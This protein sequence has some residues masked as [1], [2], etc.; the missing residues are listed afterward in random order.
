MAN[1]TTEIQNQLTQSQPGFMGTVGEAVGDGV[2]V[3]KV[4]GNVGIHFTPLGITADVV[5]TIAG[6]VAGIA[7]LG[8]LTLNPGGW[9]I[10]G[11]MLAGG[12]VGLVGTGAVT[13]F[14]GGWL[15]RAA[16]AAVMAPVGVGMATFEKGAQWAFGNKG[17]S[18]QK[19]QQRADMVA[20]AADQGVRDA[21]RLV[22]MKS[23]QSQIQQRRA[24][25]AQNVH[26][27]AQHA[28]PDAPSAMT[29]QILEKGK[30]NHV[31]PEA[32]AAA[33]MEAQQPGASAQ[34]KG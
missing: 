29:Q 9:L 6:A 19:I 8:V 14:V 3:G 4:V 28:N 15:G 24:D 17:P 22:E 20:S 32:I 5:G 11:S 27:I 10:L 2:K 1:T 25:A 21:T 26:H 23:L 33:K 30:G 7:L 16:G 31:S 12:A 18:Q 34:A 13:S